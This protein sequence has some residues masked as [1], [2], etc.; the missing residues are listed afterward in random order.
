MKFSEKLFQLRKTAGL[1]QEELANKL[2]LSRQAIY[3][4]E[5]DIAM[6]DIAKIKALAQ[7]FNVSCDYLINDDIESMEVRVIEKKP[8]TYNAVFITNNKLDYYQVDIDHGYTKERKEHEKSS[9]EIFE[10]R[11]NVAEKNLKSAGATEILWLQNDAVIACFFDSTRN[12]FGF[13]FDDKIQFVSPIENYIS[14]RI[15]TGNESA[16]TSTAPKTVAIFGQRGV[17]GVG[18]GMTTNSQMVPPTAATLIISYRD[19]SIIKE[20]EMGFNTNGMHLLE[21]AKSVDELHLM[22]EGKMQ[23]LVKCLERLNLFFENLRDKSNSIINGNAPASTVDSAFY[24]KKNLEFS[25]E[26]DAYI[27][28]ISAAAKRSNAKAMV[29]KLVCGVMIAA[30]VVVVIVLTVKYFQWQFGI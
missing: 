23:A 20:Y 16:L 5:A 2:D 30:V 29:K 15:K 27:K 14:M 12:V 25:S 10:K 17:E 18:F 22:Y 8:F 3:K 11:R 6:P 9:D 21:I 13:Y 28:K 4:W 7:L 19:R 24:T 26:H 1:S